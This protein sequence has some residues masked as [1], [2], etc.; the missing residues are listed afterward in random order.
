MR[1][2]ATLFAHAILGSHAINR[3]AALRAVCLVPLLAISLLQFSNLDL[4]G[5]GCFDTWPAPL[6]DPAADTDPSAFQ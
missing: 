1:A 5:P 4:F 2:S 6:I 3:H